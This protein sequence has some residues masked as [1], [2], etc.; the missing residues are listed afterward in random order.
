VRGRGRISIVKIDSIDSIE[1]EGNYVR[2]HAGAQSYMHRRIHRSTI[3]NVTRITEIH[4]LFNGD[5]SIVLKTGQ[6]LTVSRTYRE[7]FLRTVE[8]GTGSE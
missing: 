2:L 6:R 8:G 7:R 5:Q 1:S 3:V 4:P